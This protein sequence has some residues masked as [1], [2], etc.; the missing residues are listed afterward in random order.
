MII[1]DFDLDNVFMFSAILDKTGLVLDV[2]RAINEIG[3][4][5]VKDKKDAKELGKSLLVSV[6]IDIMSKILTSA[7]KAKTEIKELMADMTGQ[8]IQKV[9][10]MGVKDMKAFFKELIE[11]EGFGDFFKSAVESASPEQ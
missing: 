6:G 10:K 3:I 7:Y 5:E 2:Q 8:D 9:G 11:K 4:D 1:K